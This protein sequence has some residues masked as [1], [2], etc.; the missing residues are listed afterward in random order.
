M[1]TRIPGNESWVQLHFACATGRANAAHRL[2]L[3]VSDSVVTRP[4]RVRG[5][6]PK[7]AAVATCA[8]GRVVGVQLVATVTA[9]L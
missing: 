6:T 7:D 5:R 1:G 4:G 8:P 2:R 3:G 9:A